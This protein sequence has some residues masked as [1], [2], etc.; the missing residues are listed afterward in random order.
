MALTTALGTDG[1]AAAPINIA[2]AMEP[3][4]FRELAVSVTVPVSEPV[5][6]GA[7]LTEIAQLD[8]AAMADVFVQSR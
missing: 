1:E 7:N 2:T 4:T 8:P 3:D 5:T 6:V